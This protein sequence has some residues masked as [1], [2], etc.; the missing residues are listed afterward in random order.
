VSERK[1]PSRRQDLLAEELGDELVL[2]DPVRRRAHCLNRIA[3][4]VFRSCDGKTTIAAIASRARRELGVE[5]HEPDIESVVGRLAQAHLLV[6]G[7]VSRRDLGRIAGAG[8]AGLVVSIAVPSVAQ[9]VQHCGHGIGANCGCASGFTCFNTASGCQCLAS[10][11][12]G[13]THC[14]GC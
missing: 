10:G 7:A 2:Y 6:A 4:M 14:A 5:V 3:K 1:L 9:A 8:L 11:T 13:L 12:S